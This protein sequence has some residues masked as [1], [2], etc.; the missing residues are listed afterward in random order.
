VGKDR[1]RGCD[2]VIHALRYGLAASSS[3]GGPGLDHIVALN[4]VAVRHAGYTRSEL[5]THLQGTMNGLEAGAHIAG[6]WRIPMVFLSAL[7]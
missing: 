1:V 3:G 2:D 5:L 4:D 7:A 6:R